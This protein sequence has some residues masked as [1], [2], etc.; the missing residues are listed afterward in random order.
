MNGKYSG[1]TIEEMA[2]AIGDYFPPDSREYETVMSDW[3]SWIN[4]KPGKR[5]A[6]KAEDGNWIPQEQP[7]YKQSFTL[8]MD[9]DT[10]EIRFKKSIVFRGETKKGWNQ[11]RH[12]ILENTSGYH[13]TV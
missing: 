1:R 4:W 11:R 2:K 8:R 7:E 5:G 13:L 6:K 9:S 12:G 10:G 3:K